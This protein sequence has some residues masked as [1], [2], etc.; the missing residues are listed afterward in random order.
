MKRNNT[1]LCACFLAG[2]LT[3][4]GCGG[5]PASWSE[6]TIDNNGRSSFSLNADNLEL[7]IGESFSLFAPSYVSEEGL[8]WLSSD[9]SIVSVDEAGELKAV[10]LGDA[11]VYAFDS[12]AIASVSIA[13]T[14]A[15]STYSFELSSYSMTIGKGEEYSCRVVATLAQ[16]GEIVKGQEIEVAKKEES[17]EGVASFRKDGDAYRFTGLNEG[18]AVYSFSTVVEGHRIGRNLLIRVIGME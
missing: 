10:D 8:S 14:A 12:R 17:V 3:L 1:M 18:C 11:V 9:P 16:D 7:S 15:S 4:A 13:V 6:T 2:V 5:S